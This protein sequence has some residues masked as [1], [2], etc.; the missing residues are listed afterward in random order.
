[1]WT[2]L[3]KAILAQKGWPLALFLTTSVL[4]RS[5]PLVACDYVYNI[6]MQTNESEPRLKNQLFD[7]GRANDEVYLVNGGLKIILSFGTISNN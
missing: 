2:N 7:I 5:G 1:M 3:K 4:S 6:Y